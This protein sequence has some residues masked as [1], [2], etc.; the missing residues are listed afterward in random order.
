MVSDGLAGSQLPLLSTVTVP[1]TVCVPVVEEIAT[2][3]VIVWVPEGTL[4]TEPVTVCVPALALMN[5]RPA[6]STEI[7][8]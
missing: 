4:V 8:E 5:T 3:P 6:E 7:C 1:T 2:V